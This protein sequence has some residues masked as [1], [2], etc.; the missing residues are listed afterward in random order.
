MKVLKQITKEIQNSRK[1]DPMYIRII[2]QKLDKQNKKKYVKNIM[3][4]I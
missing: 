3:M 1:K 2:T 4:I